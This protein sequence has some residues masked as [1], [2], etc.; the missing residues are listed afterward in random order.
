MGPDV[1]THRIEMFGRC[2]P[3]AATHDIID[4]LLMVC[5]DGSQFS[6]FGTLPYMLGIVAALLVHA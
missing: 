4:H 3:G 1:R 6:I 5:D 2:V